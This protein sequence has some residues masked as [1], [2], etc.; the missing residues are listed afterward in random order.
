MDN[1]SDNQVVGGESAITQQFSVGAVL[2]E[3]RE[4]Q[5]LSVADVAN[6]IKFA[7]RQIEA[8]EADD[9]AHLPEATFVRGFVRSYARLLEIDPTPL[10]AALPQTHLQA[11]AVPENKAVEVPFQSVLSSRRSNIVW[12][13]G[14]LVIVLVLIIFSRMHDS[15]PEPAKPVTQANVE[16]LVLPAAITAASAPLADA[17]PAAQAVMPQAMPKPAE[18]SAA[19][20]VKNQSELDR[21][22]KKQAAKVQADQELV[23]KEQAARERAARKQATREQAGQEQLA[24]EP[25][26]LERTAKKQAATEQLATPSKPANGA[27]EVASLRLVFDEDSWVDVKDAN[28]KIL[29]SKMNHAGSLVR[30]SGTAPLSVVIGHASGVHLFYKNKEVNLAPH[31]AVEVARLLLE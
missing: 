8:M 12:L 25:A 1:Q 16:E 19:A 4:Q 13:A 7:P 28:G 29:L 22:S 9:F 27:A 31:T 6:R 18:Q 21:A 23:Q 10:L 5:G 17:L 15:S 26:A 30:L 11:A 24:R 3:A 20:A 2:R 14:G